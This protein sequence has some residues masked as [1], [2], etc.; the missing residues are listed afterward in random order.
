MTLDVYSHVLLHDGIDPA[1]DLADLWLAEQLW[2][3]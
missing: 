3:S 2:R 1:T